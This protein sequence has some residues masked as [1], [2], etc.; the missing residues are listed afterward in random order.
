VEKSERKLPTIELR[1]RV[2]PCG[3]WTRA[4]SDPPPLGELG[5]CADCQESA[6]A[7]QLHQRLLEHELRGV[8]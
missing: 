2:L 5:D 4:E 6:S 1:W 8:V 7:V 3:H